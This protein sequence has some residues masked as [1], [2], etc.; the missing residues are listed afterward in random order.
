[1]TRTTITFGRILGG[2]WDAEKYADVAGLPIPDPMLIRIAQLG[3]S[4]WTFC[5]LGCQIRRQNVQF[6]ELERDDEICRIDRV[7]NLDITNW[8]API[9]VYQMKGIS[10]D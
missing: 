10:V 8:S 3:L 2:K 1:M 7:G 9:S 5:G 6:V 4:G